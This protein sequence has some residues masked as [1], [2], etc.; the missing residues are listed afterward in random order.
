MADPTAT[1]ELDED[2][3]PASDT[4]QSDQDL[5]TMDAAIADPLTPSPVQST[6]VPQAS[7]TVQKSQPLAPPAWKDIQ[8]DPA[9][10]KMSDDKQKTAFVKWVADSDQYLTQSLTPRLALNQFNSY[11]QIQGQKMGMGFVFNDQGRP[12]TQSQRAAIDNKPVPS[13]DLQNFGYQFNDWPVTVPVA[14]KS[15][16]FAGDVESGMSQGINA[17]DRGFINLGLAAGDYLTAAGKLTDKAWSNISG[18]PSTASNDMYGSPDAWGKAINKVRLDQK[19]YDAENPSNLIQKVGGFEGNLISTF[20][21]GAGVKA[22]GALATLQAG[23]E[24]YHNAIDN[25]ANPTQASLSAG[26]A[27]AVSAATFGILH[28]VNVAAIP[29]ILGNKAPLFLAGG[30]RPTVSEALKLTGLDAAALGATGYTGQVAQNLAD[31]NLYDPNRTL[32]EGATESAVKTAAFA[33]LHLPTIASA[34]WGART[35]ITAANRDV[36]NAANQVALAKKG[37]DQATIDDAQKAYVTARENLDNLITDT[38]KNAPPPTVDEAQDAK[39]QVTESIAQKD[40]AAASALGQIPE[41]PKAS[42]QILDDIISTTENEAA[43]PAELP[44]IG[45]EAPEPTISQ[46]TESPVQPAQ[47]QTAQA[48]GP[49]TTEEVTRQNG[50]NNIQN[51]RQAELGQPRPVLD[52]AELG[53]GSGSGHAG[54]RGNDGSGTSGNVEAGDEHPPLA[55]ENDAQDVSSEPQQEG[56]SG[57]P[58]VPSAEEASGM[59]PDEQAAHALGQT[60]TP[61]DQLVET[62]LARNAKIDAKIDQLPKAIQKP[63][64]DFIKAARKWGLRG[65]KNFIV[66]TRENAPVFV[67]TREGDFSTVYINPIILAREDAALRA[68]GYDQKQINYLH[69]LRFSEEFEH[70]I[71]G[72][73]IHDEWKRL[74]GKGDFS[75]YYDKKFASIYDAMT[76]K[77]KASL[78]STYK[79]DL[80]DVDISK[81]SSETGLD[82]ASRF[83]EEFYRQTIQRKEGGTVTE[84]AITAIRNNKPMKSIV[85]GIVRKLQSMVEKLKSNGHSDPVIENLIN[86]RKRLLDQEATEITPKKSKGKRTSKSSSI[87]PEDYDYTASS[88]YEE[89]ARFQQE[90]LRPSRFDS[91]ADEWNQKLQMYKHVE[92]PNEYQQELHNMA[93]RMAKFQFGPDNSNRDIGEANAFFKV[94]VLARKWVSEGKSLEKFGASKVIRHSLLDDGRKAALRRGEILKK[95]EEVEPK[96]NESEE[97]EETIH[98]KG[99]DTSETDYDANQSQFE[100]V[101]DSGNFEGV[102]ETT[103]RTEANN[104]HV[105]ANIAKVFEGTSPYEHRLMELHSDYPDTWSKKA[106][107]EFG[108]SEPVIE[109]DFNDLQARVQ[110]RISQAGLGSHDFK[111]ISSAT[112]IDEDQTKTPAF[113]RWFGRSWITADDGTPRVVYHG[114]SQHFDRFDPSKKGDNTGALSANKGY[115]FTDN[116]GVASSYSEMGYRNGAFY[117]SYHGPERTLEELRT[118]QNETKKYGNVHYNPITG[119]TTDT[120]SPINIVANDWAVKN[121][122][123][124]ME[125][126]GTFKE[127]MENHSAGNLSKL[128]GGKFEIHDNGQGG[129]V[130]PVYLSI[131]NPLVHDFQ[132]KP[133]REQTYNKLLRKA[134]DEGRDGVIFRRTFDDPSVE[135]PKEGDEPHTIYVAFEPEQIKSAIGNSGEFSPNDSRITAAASLNLPSKATVIDNLKKFADERTKLGKFTDWAKYINHY[136]TVLAQGIQRSNAAVREFLKLLPDRTVSGGVIRYIEAAGDRKTLESWAKQTAAN[137][138]TKHLAP[139]YEAALRLT[140]DQIATANK[141][142]HLLEATR[143]LAQTWGIEIAKRDN[144]FPRT[145]DEGQGKLTGSGNSLSTTFKN[146]KERTHHTMFD[147]EQA[148]VTYK[149]KDVAEGVG[150]YLNDLYRAVAA[151]KFI[152]SAFQ[153]VAEDGRKMLI[154]ATSS[155]KEVTNPPKGQVHLVSDGGPRTNAEDYVHIPDVYALKNWAYAGKINGVPVMHQ[156]DLLVHPKIAEKINN[157]FGNADT[158]KKW[159]G[160][161]SETQTE[162]LHKFVSKLVRNDIN[163]IAKSNLFALSPIFHPIQ[164][165]AEA[166]AHGNTPMARKAIVDALKYLPSK[167]IR[168]MQGI[169]PPDFNNPR[170]AWWSDMG[171]IM[172]PEESLLSAE[173]HSQLDLTFLRTAEWLGEKLVAKAAGKGPLAEKSAKYIH[174]TAAY[175]KQANADAQNWIF[176]KYIPANKLYN[177]ETALAANMRRFSKELASGEYTEEQVAKQTADSINNA[178]GHLNYREMARSPV[179]QRMMNTVLLAPDFFEARQKHLGQ[180]ILGA[181]GN[182]AGRENFVAM[183]RMGL[184]LGVSAQVANYL[185]NGETYWQDHPFEV[186]IGN[187]FYGFRTAVGD[188]RNL[189]KDSWDIATWQGKGLPYAANRMSPLSRFIEESISGVNWRGEKIPALSAVTDLIAGATPMVGQGYLSE[190]PGMDKVFVSTKNNSISPFE[191]ALGALGV[192]ISRYSPI[193]DIKVKA[194]DWVAKNPEA[195]GIPVERANATYPVSAYRPLEYALDDGDFDAAFQEY[196]KLVNTKGYNAQK[197]DSG[198]Q[199]SLSHSYTGSSKGD[200]AF[201]VQLDASDKQLYQAAKEREKILMVRY[202]QMLQEYRK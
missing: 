119:E 10:S 39:A 67:R 93:K 191:S 110:T 78:Q 194:H 1:A 114:T 199:Q 167:T 132:G 146:A 98:Q 129:N 178:Y 164:I 138:K 9:F 175:V 108:L 41:E 161:P 201:V 152:A 134:K 74:G 38:A 25:G 61:H 91:K 139:L 148:G 184:A 63:T 124:D 122:I 150:A 11:V 115:F 37:T 76:K 101:G 200:Q 58:S 133:Y 40:D 79:G 34:M 180:A 172:K 44:V 136:G 176:Q 48:V 19:L 157:V 113:K 198:I 104:A 192:K 42:T 126:G 190:I 6:P 17:I 23:D 111:R 35:E 46:P 52:Q 99:V 81:N 131:K 100:G 75:D 94:S 13:G 18:I 102:T 84:D 188:A 142:S 121:V 50:Q 8:T 33:L 90:G 22:I 123:K 27:T 118:L 95:N 163:A 160:E 137:P 68:N 32:T 156:T 140:P 7:P 151:R 14:P 21:G 171:L 202:R 15:T 3:A 64:H 168:G 186:K 97:A 20:S 109:K 77:Q 2:T 127:A 195:S 158:L 30:Y 29:S 165:G 51:Q 83:G 189:F 174:A 193:S 103:P 149:T 196:Q 47:S 69:E 162:A 197:V 28:G 125:S 177:A 80:K 87:E 36:E 179:V 182:K 166:L 105:T 106:A 143:Q 153:G 60:V 71:G 82:D 62:P 112:P 159:W 70:N 183:A 26:V 54:E 141:V 53:Q 59:T 169:E 181:T 73:V 89:P 135:E 107:D 16:T 187:R 4:T 31:K 92:I 86:D 24:T 66:D 85:Q 130:L 88:E 155:W 170:T 116:P 45:E 5:D 43:K 12:M 57:K 154:P 144:Y 120:F 56:G 55:H 185:A 65:V 49:L 96:G 145:V 128:V 72:R 147:G 173:G 117:S